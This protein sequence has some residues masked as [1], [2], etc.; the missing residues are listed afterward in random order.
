MFTEERQ[1]E[2]RARVD[3]SPLIDIVFLLLIFFSVTTTFL[4]QAGLDLELPEST[5]ASASENT[6]I[7]VEIGADGTVLFQGETV[8][9]EVLEQRVAALAEEERRRVT[10]RA[11]RQLELGLAITV[12]DAL[13][14]AG[15]EGIALPMVPIEER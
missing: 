13:R 14:R 9:P 1:R 8:T 15:A 4:E 2:R 12:I 7:I 6:A 10:V 11:D 3:I 5:T